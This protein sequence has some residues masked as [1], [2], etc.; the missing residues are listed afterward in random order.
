MQAIRVSRRCWRE[1]T[2]DSQSEEAASASPARSR[3]DDSNAA[4]RVSL[5]LRLTQVVHEVLPPLWLAGMVTELLERTDQ[6]LVAARPVTGSRYEQGATANN[7]MVDDATKGE[8]ASPAP[9]DKSG[10]CDRPRVQPEMQ[11]AVRI[12]I[13]DWSAARGPGVPGI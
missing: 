9:G 6:R 1:E 2:I 11:W 4:V 12:G 7:T 8:P 5:R 10:T 3:P 13:A